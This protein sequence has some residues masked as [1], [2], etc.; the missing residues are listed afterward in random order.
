[1]V[2]VAAA[3]LVY[4]QARNGRQLS[5][6]GRHHTTIDLLATDRLAPF[7]RAGMLGVFLTMGGLAITPLQALDAQFRLE[8]YLWAII[9]ALPAA[10][11]LLLLPMWGIH[12]RLQEEKAHAL[13]EI[14]AAIDAADHGL[15]D[16][17]LNRLNALTMRRT[18]LKGVHEWP[19]D[20]KAVTRV[21]FYLIIPPLAWVAAALVEM[22]LE[23]AL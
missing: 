19:L 1:M 18:L 22:A 23:R 10:A 13:G 6:V 14:D 9:F 3:R 20:V 2:W 5:L 4:F 21:G 12:R 7:A 11:T 16:A 8:N 17:A 15:D